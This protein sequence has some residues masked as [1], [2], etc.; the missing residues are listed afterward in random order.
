MPHTYFCMTDTFDESAHPRQDEGRF[1]SKVQTA[2]EASISETFVW[3]IEGDDHEA[4]IVEAATAAEALEGA[5]AAF[6]DRYGE[7]YNED[8]LTVIGAFR[9]DVDDDPEDWVFA[10]PDGAPESE[11]AARRVIEQ[12]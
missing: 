9:G 7:E 11:A 8:L 1:A 12:I 2:P 4:E 5:A 10:T 3:V 6:S